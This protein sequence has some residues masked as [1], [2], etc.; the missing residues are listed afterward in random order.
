MII[1]NIDIAKR[2]LCLRLHVII[3]NI[4]IAKRNLCLRLHVIICNIDIAKRNL[5]LRLHVII[6][7]ID[8]AKRNLCLRLYVIICSK[9]VIRF[10]CNIC[11]KFSSFNFVLPLYI[12]T[13]KLNVN[14]AIIF[15]RLLGTDPS[16]LF[17]SFTRKT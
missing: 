5:C 12:Q 11:F 9:Q 7:N 16:I 10:F 8:I 14:S 6:C 1:C 13:R 15:L 3:C 4:D 2:N 17:N